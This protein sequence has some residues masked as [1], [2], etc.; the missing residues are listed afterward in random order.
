MLKGAILAAS[1]GGNCLG[2]ITADGY[3]ISDD[4]SCGF[5]SSTG[6][7]GKTIGDNVDPLLDPD[8]LEDN[9]GPTQTISLLSTSPAVDA[10]PVAN[11]PVT[12]DQRGAPRP[13]PED[14]GNAACDIGAFEFGAVVPIPTPPDSDPDP[15]L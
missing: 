3:N 7:N 14:A 12:T 8:G 9:G 15:N 1:T 10:I 5:G 6:A 11:C 13:D 4:N 2:T